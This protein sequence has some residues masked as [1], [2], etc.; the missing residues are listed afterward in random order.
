MNDRLL[1]VVVREGFKPFESAFL[2]GL[3]SGKR[4]PFR[5]MEMARI[6]FTIFIGF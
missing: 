4:R 5:Y 3:L 1:S 6:N 2:D